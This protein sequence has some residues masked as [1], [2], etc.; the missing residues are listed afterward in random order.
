MNKTLIEEGLIKILLSEPTIEDIRQLLNADV[1]GKDE[2]KLCNE[3]FNNYSLI[4]NYQIKRI[5]QEYGYESTYIDSINVF[6][7]NEVSL[8]VGNLIINRRKIQNEKLYKLALDSSTYNDF[9]ENSIDIINRRYKSVIQ[10]KE[11]NVLEDLEDYYDLDNKEKGLSFQLDKLDEITDGIP[12]GVT[13]VIGNSKE[14]RHVYAI[15]LTYNL[16]SKAK[17]VLYISFNYSKKQSLLDLISRHSC[18][19]EKFNKSL[20]RD[21][22]ITM[23]DENTYKT[24][25]YDL[26]DNLKSHLIVF[27]VD[28]C[29][30]QNVFAFQRMIAYASKIFQKN[31]NST[32]DL[33]I[34]DGMEQLHIDTSRKVITNRN[35][36]E[37]EYYSFFNDSQYPIVITN[38]SL[39]DFADKINDGTHFQLCYLSEATRYYSKVII[40]VRGNQAM[41][42]AKEMKLS[43]LKNPN[44]K[45]IDELLI[46]ADKQCSYIKYETDNLD[47]ASNYEIKYGRLERSCNKIKEENKKLEQQVVEL[48]QTIMNNST[49]IPL[50]DEENKLLFEGMFDEL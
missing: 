4:G 33:I 17:N 48:N 24:I 29:N 45:T 46:V 21:E 11:D 14:Y 20:N 50:T 16:I 43:L 23:N 49:P 44:D 2:E 31:N 18:N 37:S 39:E 47:D 7:K 1:L 12:I 32:I 26:V 27:D 19:N 28:N 10:V 5:L 35:T 6:D 34:I 9:N 36:V 41:D 13:T 3:L 42:K 25:Y 15:N 22:L 30:V 8:E 40:S 38:E